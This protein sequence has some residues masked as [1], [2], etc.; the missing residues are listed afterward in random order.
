MGVLSHLGKNGPL[1]HSLIVTLSGK[2][3]KAQWQVE[4][5]ILLREFLLCGECHL[6]VPHPYAHGDTQEC[7]E[8]LK[9][10]RLQ[11][12]HPALHAH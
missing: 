1:S 5:C 4:N 6:W 7:L 9:N 12:K 8:N 10:S 3:K 11:V 2:V